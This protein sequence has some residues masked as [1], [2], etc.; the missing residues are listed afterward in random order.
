MR[1]PVKRS[2]DTAVAVA[3]LA[4][5]VVAAAF[6]AVAARGATDGQT[7][8]AFSGTTI[9]GQSVSLASY[10]GKPLVLVFWASW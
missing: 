5:A 7:A 1:R 3:L 4:I 8:P 2:G 9:D 6:G 10:L